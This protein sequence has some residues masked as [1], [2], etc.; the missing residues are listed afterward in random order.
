MQISQKTELCVKFVMKNFNFQKFQEVPTGYF[1]VVEIDDLDS[2]GV[3]FDD[4]DVESLIQETKVST[5]EGSTT[6]GKGRTEKHTG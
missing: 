1:D 2:E 4:S 6:R 3:D 5:R